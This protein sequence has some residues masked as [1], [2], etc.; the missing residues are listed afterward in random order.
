MQSLADL[1]KL[2]RVPGVKESEERRVCA[3]AIEA[4]LKHPVQASQ[5]RYKAGVLSLSV[6]SVLRSEIILHEGKLRELLGAAGLSLTA[7][8]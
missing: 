3:G 4:L 7:I 6:P 2:H 8:R 1:L 5:V